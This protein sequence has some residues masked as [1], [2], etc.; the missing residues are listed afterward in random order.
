MKLTATA[1][2]KG[3]AAVAAG[4]VLAAL[5]GCSGSSP[6][7][8]G[9]GS[10]GDAGSGDTITFMNWE[11]LEGSP[12]EKVLQQFTAD[13]GI[14]VEYQFSASG[15]D[16][17]PK[18]RAV[19]GSNNPP[20][21]M[22]IDDDFLPYY[23]STGKLLDLRAD[24]EK[25]GLKADDYYESVYDNSKQPDGSVV[26]WSLG[27]QPRVIFYNKDMFEEAGVPLPPSTWTDDGW[28]WDDFLDAAKKL[29]VPNERWGADVIDDSAYETI[30]GVNN[31]STGRW[32]PDGKGLALADPKGQEAVQF[33]A[34]LTCEHGVQPTWS[35]LQQDGRGAE[36]FASG[37]IGMIERASGFV[38]Y[39][40]TN[41]KDFEWD[42]APVPGNVAQKTQ[43]NQVVFA[44]PA[45]AAHQDAAW[46]LLEYL[47]TMD[48]AEVFA[49]QG[50][51]V[52]GYKP[53]AELAGEVVE[54]QLPASLPLVLQAADNSYLSGRV[55]NIEEAIG[56][57]RPALDPVKNCQAKASD[58]L[59]EV[60]PQVDEIINR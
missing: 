7:P 33:V 30:F 55:A 16:Y 6:A 29:S 20:D 51:F 28:T 19:L 50:S 36:M 56:V 22:R 1:T 54:G 27:I 18:T 42:V 58:V 2:Q 48:G 53:A 47:T 24:I 44:I 60:E 34:D 59:P 35:E 52:P 39:F 23:A 37:E 46:R 41:V 21:I 40:R 14:K 25:S 13:T 4:A 3:V 12:Y 5:A 43:G 9:S 38:N 15:S 45:A 31:G 10:G 49:E 26:G 11:A 57:Y 8:G 32:T 17:W